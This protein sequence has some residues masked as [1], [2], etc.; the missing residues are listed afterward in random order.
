M[1][2]LN[3]LVNTLIKHPLTLKQFHNILKKS[4]TFFDSVE[5]EQELLL[6]NGLPLHF[7][8][9]QVSLKTV[10]TLIKDQ[11]FCIVDIETTAGNAKDGQIIEIGAVRYKNGQIIE[12]YDTLVNTGEIPKKIQEL[13][14]ITPSMTYTAPN[15][16]TVLEEFKVFLEDD[17]FV[18]HAISFDYKFISD[19]FKKYDLG[20][21][22]NRRICTIELSKRVIECER[23]GLK[24]LKEHLNINIDN[25]HRA[26]SDALSTQKILEICLKQ[27]PKEVVTAED[28]IRFT[29]H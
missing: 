9:D 17:L 22:C 13:T 4:D 16:K 12:K 7:S 27:L 15:L 14:N 28:L 10:S 20:Q 11:T 25:H 26:F 2:Y 19:S 21:L 29:K 24:Y 1:N 18:A 8:N 23:Y 6:S 5:L 3:K